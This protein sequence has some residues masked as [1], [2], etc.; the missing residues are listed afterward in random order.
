M[1]TAKIV[2]T[3]EEHAEL[4]RR[5]RSATISQRDGRRARV[6][7]LASQGCTR[8]EIARLTGLSLA[9]IT[10]W[11][12]RFQAQRLDGLV[13]KPGRGRKPSLPLEAVQRVIEQ[14][15]KPRIG[16]P[17]WS[18]RSMARAAGIS[19]TSVHK[20][21]AANDLKPHLTRTFKLSNDPNFEEKFWDVIGLYLDPPEKALVLCCNEKS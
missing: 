19:A 4:S 6:I 5:V 10:G 14:V 2:L 21:W 15:T 16:E 3:P 11:C 7:L 20:I 13:D 9:V 1:N 18:C 12:Q 17:R 8:A